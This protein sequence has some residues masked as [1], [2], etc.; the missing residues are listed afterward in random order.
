M[1]VTSS[2]TLLAVHIGLAGDEESP[3]NVQLNGLFEGRQCM[4]VALLVQRE[5]R[6]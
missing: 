1:V 5:A 3:K 4:R 2:W 6:A